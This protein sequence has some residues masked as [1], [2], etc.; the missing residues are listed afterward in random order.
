MYCKN[1]GFKLDEDSRF[2]SK[3]GLNL[4]NSNSSN[5][6]TLNDDK[7]IF[8][9]KPKFDLLYKVLKEGGSLLIVLFLFSYS[10]LYILEGSLIFAI[11]LLIVILYLVIKLPIEKKQY[12]NLVY[13]FYKTKV[14]YKDGFINKEEKELKYKYIREVVMSQN[15]LERFCGIG[16]IKIFT[17]ASTGYNSRR[18]NMGSQNGIYI[19]C[20]PN[21]NKQYKRIKQI[22]NQ[23]ENK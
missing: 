13:N 9:L 17:S 19:H 14:E 15:I 7:V 1:C 12:D 5:N 10:S 6:K 2:C 3:C 22:I 23:E 11:I 8:S 20:V 16:T 21:V 4:S 18:G